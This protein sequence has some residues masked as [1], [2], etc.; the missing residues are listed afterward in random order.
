MRAR[1]HP[2]RLCSHAAC[3]A[4]AH[5]SNLRRTLCLELCGSLLPCRSTRQDVFNIAG[6]MYAAV[7]F[8]GCAKTATCVGDSFALVSRD[9][10]EQRC[11]QGLL[12][13]SRVTLQGVQLVDR[14]VRGPTFPC[15]TPA[16]PPRRRHA[17]AYCWRSM[18]AALSA[19]QH[20]VG[21]VLLRA[22][23]HRGPQHPR[24]RQ[25]H[26][27][28]G[29]RRV[30]PRARRGL[31]QHAA[32]RAGPGAPRRRPTCAHIAQLFA[33]RPA[34]AM[35][36]ACSMAAW[37]RPQASGSARSCRH[38]P[39]PCARAQ[40][41]IELPYVFV[42]TCIYSVCP[43]STHKPDAA[44]CCSSYLMTHFG[45]YLSVC[46]F[47]NRANC[48]VARGAGADIQ[49]DPICVD[50]RQVLPLLHVHVRDAAL[51]HVLW[52][53]LGASDSIMAPQPATRMVSGRAP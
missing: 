42:Q 1:R 36:L 8:L 12:T 29:A 51:L 18:L 37:R 17:R 35:S 4:A 52:H 22:C 10:R 27:V 50:A 34:L 28:R 7:L 49:H 41:V 6:A 32:V 14:P 5:P 44:V 23:M 11:A 13:A 16:L 2:A 3:R 39:M 31:L 30:V 24:P 53:G 9:G 46:R 20:E 25:A 48:R 43:H 21:G 38:K 33:T 40:V 19:M 15:C 26:H 45:V 47:D